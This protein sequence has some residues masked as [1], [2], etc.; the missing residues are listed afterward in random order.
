MLVRIANTNKWTIIMPI[1][2]VN[3]TQ[4]NILMEQIKARLT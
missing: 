4:S 1:V 3:A 2:K